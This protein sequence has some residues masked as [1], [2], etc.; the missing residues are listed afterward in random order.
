MLIP[1][2]FKTK[3]LIRILYKSGNSH[4]FWVYDYTCRDGEHKWSAC[5]FSSRP[6]IIGVDEMEAIF[7]VK[8]KVNI[9]TFLKRSTY[10]S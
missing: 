1:T 4:K 10:E 5:S 6:L 8:K 7:I 9:I 3:F 2:L